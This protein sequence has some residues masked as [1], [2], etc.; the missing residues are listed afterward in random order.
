[1]K[2]DRFP[3]G[4]ENDMM[5]NNTNWLYL[6][7]THKANQSIIYV[8]FAAIHINMNMM[9]WLSMIR[10]SKHLEKIYFHVKPILSTD[11][12][13]NYQFVQECENSSFSLKDKMLCKQILAHSLF[14][15]VL[16][17]STNL[18]ILSSS[19]EK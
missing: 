13:L 4:V 9:D 8:K 11:P 12:G 16:P 6:F 15:K 1:M 10:F 7:R 19:H 17:Y 5:W 14:W 3:R 2:M 18:H